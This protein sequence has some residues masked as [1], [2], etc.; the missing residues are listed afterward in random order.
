ME[1]APH[2]ATVDDQSAADPGPHRQVDGHLGVAGGP[3]APFGQTG[4]VHIGVDADRNV[5]IAPDL[6][7]ERET[8]PTRLG[9]TTHLPGPQIDRPERTDTHRGDL[10]EC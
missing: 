10:S 9:R 8:R 4:G 2:G 6:I 1:E 7:D 3:P 5:Q